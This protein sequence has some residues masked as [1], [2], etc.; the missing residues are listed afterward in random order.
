MKI[1]GIIFDIDG[2]L[3]RG[4][5][6]IPGAAETVNKLRELGIKIIFLS[7]LSTKSREEYVEILENKI[8]IRVSPD[9]LVLATSATADYVAKH[10]TTKKVYF[11][12]HKGLRKELEK[13]GLIIVDDPE[14]AEFVVAGSPFDEKGYVTEENRWKFTGA[15]RAIL[16]AKAKFVAV[17]PD[18]LFP[19]ADGK[20]IPGTGTFIG[21][22]SAATGVEPIIIGKPSKEIYRIALSKLGVSPSEAV[23]VGDQ[24][25]T[26][27]IPAKKLG[28]TTALVLTGLTK[29]ED[30]D[31][32]DEETRRMIDYVFD[33]VKDVLKLVERRDYGS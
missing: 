32:L 2:V 18:K 15:V 24:L 22:I 17:N 30:L 11:I 9:E 23:M 4:S 21:A 28:M 3:K 8:G 14:E 27:I 25:Y 26:D 29:K 13:A 31:K 7:N 12:G 20:P 16:L 10:S 6:P 19:G 5:Q 33:S 1:K